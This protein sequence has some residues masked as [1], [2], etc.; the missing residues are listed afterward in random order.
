MAGE[1]EERLLETLSRYREARRHT[2][3]IDERPGSV[4]E[5]ITRERLGELMEEVREL[6]KEMGEIKRLLVGLFIS[7]ALTFV[8]VIVDMTLRS[9]GVL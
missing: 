6:K 9:L 5:M 2:S 7:L 8:G 1:G 3:E 4:Y